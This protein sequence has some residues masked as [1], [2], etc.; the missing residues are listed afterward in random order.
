VVSIFETTNIIPV[1]YTDKITELRNRIY[2]T[3]AEPRSIGFVYA[4]PDYSGNTYPIIGLGIGFP[5]FLPLG[6][7]KL[8]SVKSVGLSMTHNFFS[9]RFYFGSW[10]HVWGLNGTASVGGEP[11]INV[12]DAAGSF[13]VRLVGALYL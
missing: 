12:G 1:Q 10:L 6:S 3:F 11:P 9:K 4:N 7:G 13:H 8:N 2:G 5:V